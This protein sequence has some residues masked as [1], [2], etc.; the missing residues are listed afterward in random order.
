MF[1]QSYCLWCTYSSIHGV[2][3]SLTVYVLLQIC[4]CRQGVTVDAPHL[5]RQAWMLFYI[6][7]F[8]L[9]ITMGC[10]LI[11]VLATP[12]KGG[13]FW[14]E[15][16]EGVT[17]MLWLHVC[18]KPLLADAVQVSY[19]QLWRMFKMQKLNFLF[20]YINWF[21]CIEALYLQISLYIWMIFLFA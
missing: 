18:L 10:I 19:I 4:N 20:L 8:N 16:K 9:L 15:Q 13:N 21:K 5:S 14:R 1:F 12:Q 2:S 3:I 17:Q 11:S 6:C 7:Q